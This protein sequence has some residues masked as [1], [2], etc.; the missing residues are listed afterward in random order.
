MNVPEAFLAIEIAN[1]RYQKTVTVAAQELSEELR[2][3]R[4]GLFEEQPK[5]MED[6]H[7]DYA[8]RKRL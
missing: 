7:E 6:V 5:A 2:R 1:E 8:A 3:I 4:S